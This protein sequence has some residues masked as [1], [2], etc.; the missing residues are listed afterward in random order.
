MHQEICGAITSYNSTDIK[1]NII[2]LSISCK[3]INL[4]ELKKTFTASQV[5]CFMYLYYKVFI[6]RSIYLVK[7]FISDS[8]FFDPDTTKQI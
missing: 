4:Q 3:F 6:P 5:S 1:K 2:Y 8:V 7:C